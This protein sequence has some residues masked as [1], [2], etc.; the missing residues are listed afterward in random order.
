MDFKIL[1]TVAD[2]GGQSAFLEMLPSLTVGP[3]LYLVFMKVKQ[4]L[5]PEEKCSL[6]ARTQTDSNTKHFENYSYFYSTFKYIACFGHS[7][8]QV[9]KYV[10]PAL[11]E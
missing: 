4:D 7:D 3:A 8:D 11:D 1:L 2:V 10:K 6:N 9:E 5:S